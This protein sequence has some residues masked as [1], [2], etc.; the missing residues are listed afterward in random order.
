[1]KPD[2]P[3]D[4][5][6]GIIDR[7]IG[8]SHVAPFDFVNGIADD[9]VGKEVAEAMKR[10]PKVIPLDPGVMP[11]PAVIVPAVKVR[12]D[13]SQRLKAALADTSHPFHQL[14]PE[15]RRMVA[16]AAALLDY[17]EWLERARR[18]GLL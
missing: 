11:H 1:M 6:Q 9:V 17:A 4:D 5:P 15:A 3:L 13:L 8:A 12:H 7:L 16:I 2:D 10:V 14:P 18:A